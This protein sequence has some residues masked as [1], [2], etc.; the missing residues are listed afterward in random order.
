MPPCSTRFATASSS[1]SVRG[2]SSPRFL[3]DEERHRHA[4]LALARQRPVRPVGDHAVQARL[5]PAGIE[6][7]RLD[8]AQRGRAQRLRGL[9]AVVPRHVV[10]AGEPLRRRAKDDR[11]LVA[12]AVHVAVRLRRPWRSSTPCSA[13]SVDDLRDSLS[14][15]DMPPKSG[16]DCDVA[17]VAHAPASGSRRP[18]C[19]SGG[20]TRSPRRRTRARCGRCR[21]PYRA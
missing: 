11:R 20:T 1:S 12:P 17:A 3:A 7:R 16:S 13:I 21:C 18:S 19:R 15:S 6:L 10:H 5:A 9:G 8:A 4:P 14:R 2:C